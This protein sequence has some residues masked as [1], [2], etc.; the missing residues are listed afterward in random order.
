M[1][2]PPASL[3]ALFAAAT[4]SSS[5]VVGFCTEMTLNPCLSNGG[6]TL[7]Q[8]DPSAH[9]PC[10]K[11]RVGFIDVDFAVWAFEFGLDKNATDTRRSVRYFICQSVC[12]KSPFSR[13]NKCQ[14]IATQLPT[15]PAS[16][17]RL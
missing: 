9:K 7:L 5:D 17:P 1:T 3:M 4:S 16:P 14:L 6:I 12:S 2:S 10:T 15:T 8:H 11:I 13:R